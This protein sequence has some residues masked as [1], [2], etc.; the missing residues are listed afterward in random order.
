MKPAFDLNLLP[1]LDALI[2]QG[3]VSG[4]A[5]LLGITQSAASH[6]LRRL[7]EHFND[8]LFVRSGSR[9]LPTPRLQALESFVRSTMEGLHSHLD[10]RFEFDPATASRTFTLSSTDM[11]EADFLASIVG[12]L[13]RQAPRCR[14]RMVPVKPRDVAGAL[15][16]GDV[17]LAI[18]AQRLTSEGLYQQRLVRNR[19]V[20]IASADSY[21]DLSALTPEAFA[22]LPHIAI[23]PYGYDED[24][25]EWAFQERGLHRRF[26]VTTRSFLA[27][28]LLVT[29]SDLVATVPETLPRHFGGLARLHCLPPCIELPPILMRQ[30]W[31]P[32]YHSDPA[33]VWLRAMIFKLFS[34]GAQAAP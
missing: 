24:L 23:N 12:E 26:V 14:L 13:R 21:P 16:S 22:D 5:E 28:P 4:A 19:L 6:A 9:M 2:S 17:D 10:P 33:N 25:Y 3:S 7:R 1:V 15:E 20:C 32:R 18:G 11:G 31:H 8:P 29:R 27:V 34:D 30:A